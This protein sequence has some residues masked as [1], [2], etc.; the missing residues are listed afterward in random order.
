MDVYVNNDRY[1]EGYEEGY[2]EGYKGGY[3]EGYSDKCDEY[4]LDFKD[5]QNK[6]LIVLK[7]ETYKLLYDVWEFLETVNKPKA[8]K[9]SRTIERFLED[10]LKWEQGQ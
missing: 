6:E 2:E 4:L 5:E 10:Y 3:D 8:S 7:D 1:R 9:L